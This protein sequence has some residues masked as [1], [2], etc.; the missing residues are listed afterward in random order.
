[1][2]KEFDKVTMDKEEEISHL[3]DHNNKLLL[4]I[5][6]AKDKA[7]DN[8]KLEEENQDLQKK[9]L[10]NIE[11]IDHLKNDKQDLMDRIQKIKDDKKA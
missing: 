7:Q 3:R 11:E 8:Q 5:K 6:K 4:Q 9:L 10:E 2:Q 1:M